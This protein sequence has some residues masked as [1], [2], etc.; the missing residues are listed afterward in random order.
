M[1]VPRGNAVTSVGSPSV[2][3]FPFTLALIIDSPVSVIEMSCMATEP[4]NVCTSCVASNF[5]SQ[6]EVSTVTAGPKQ[7]TTM[8][9]TSMS[10]IFPLRPLSKSHVCCS[11]LTMIDTVYEVS[12]ASRSG[13]WNEPLLDTVSRVSTPS[14]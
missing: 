1:V 11:G 13:N 10:A 7:A 12:G 6:G 8:F 3:S 2:T 5:Q 14:A 9:V 4:A